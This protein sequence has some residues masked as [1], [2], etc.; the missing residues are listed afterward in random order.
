MEKQLIQIPIS[1]NAAN[2]TPSLLAL[3]KAMLTL[4][5]SKGYGEIRIHHILTLAG[6][7]RSTFYEHVQSKD[8]LLASCLTSPLRVLVK[9]SHSAQRNSELRPLL[10]HFWENKHLMREML[11]GIARRKLTQHLVFLHQEKLRKE[12][13][14]VSDQRVEATL[15]MITQAIAEQQM[16]LLADWLLG[17]H[18]CELETLA[19]ALESFSYQNYLAAKQVLGI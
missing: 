7:A 10:L 3:Q 19:V 12:L 8:A 6:I 4:I 17:R 16:C 13:A 1:S 18:P 15:M 14:L 5:V 2:K 9:H 11:T